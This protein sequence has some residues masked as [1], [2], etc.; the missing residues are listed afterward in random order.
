MDL[1]GQD[2]ELGLLSKLAVGLDNRSAIDVGAEQGAL[3]AGML[4]AGVQALH[5]F[6]PHPANAQ[7]LRT[8]F[9]GDPRVTVHECAVS[10]SDGEAE[11]HVSTNPDGT[12]VSFGHTLLERDDTEEI[13]W[14]STLPVARRSLHSLAQAGEIPR[15]VGILKIDTEG[16]DLAVVQGMGDLQAEVVMVEHWTYLPNGLGACPWSAQEMAAVLRERGFSH[17]AFVVH[18]GDFVTLKWDD[19]DV[20]RG[21]MG[22]LVFIHDDALERLLPTVLECAGTFAERTVQTAHSYRRAADDRTTV[23]EELRRVVDERSR[24]IEELNAAVADRSQRAQELE[25]LANERLARIEELE[26]VATDRL[27]LVNNLEQV[28][29]DRLAVVDELKQ[30]ADARLQALEAVTAQL[31]TQS[32]ELETLRRQLLQDPA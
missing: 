12:P 7:A 13:A 10:D 4:D 20:E 2:A 19:G 1:Y 32:A 31:N 21:A 26:G 6:D 15:S 11:L 27:D 14:T 5:V 28:A 18:R 29:A 23:I 22:N 17:F 9:A 8:R 30:A 24:V 3:A 25:T 16:H